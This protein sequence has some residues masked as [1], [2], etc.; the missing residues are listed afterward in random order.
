[1][2]LLDF[3]ASKTLVSL[4]GTFDHLES[5][6]MLLGQTSGEESLEDDGLSEVLLPPTVQTPEASIIVDEVMEQLLVNVDLF[7]DDEKI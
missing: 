5:S 7:T 1:M 6:D 2:L 4:N 3:W